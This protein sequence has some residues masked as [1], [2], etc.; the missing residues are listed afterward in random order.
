MGT[1]KILI[2][3]DD[4]VVRHFL[5]RMLER[6][7]H[8][9]VTAE[10]GE[11]A[12][13]IIQADQ[14]LDVFLF[15]WMMPRRD[16]ISLCRGLR[17]LERPGYPYIILLTSRSEKQDVRAG[18]AAGAD[19]FLT[20]PVEWEQLVMRLGVAKRII[21]LRGEV[22][23][24]ARENEDLKHL[25]RLKSAFL[26]LVSH[27]VRSPLVVLD[28][29]LRL[30]QREVDEK[31]PALR[32][33]VQSACIGS[34]RL[35]DLFVRSLKL[36]QSDE[37]PEPLQPS[38]ADLSAV[39]RETVEELRSFSDRRDQHVRLE[40]LDHRHVAVVD[41]SKIKDAL[42]N[43]LMN[44]IKFTPNGREIVVMVEDAGDSVWLGVKDAGTGVR[45]EDQAH[46]WDTY[47]S[48]FDMMHHS[49]GQY[50]YQ[51]RGVGLGLAI[52]KQF[53][54]LH[55]G[56]VGFD[57]RPDEGTTFYFLVPKEGVPVGPGST[58]EYGSGI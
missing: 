29:T 45:P 22:R 52:V 17:G 48:T 24:Q 14:Q 28:G 37:V 41:R 21:G 19:D 12:W 3:E 27:E 32:D 51:K 44:A 42:I 46:V 30:L 4:A 23:E 6:E 58:A 31:Q 16:G 25:D 13:S 39:A 33:L 49:S 40:G 5:Q 50:E 38:E 26:R 55:G 9:V 34:D 11:E 18:M 7:G 8:D 54:E 47:F 53:V 36:A 2:A 15:D 57:T 56:E 1:M 10:D 35:C 43:L 20:K